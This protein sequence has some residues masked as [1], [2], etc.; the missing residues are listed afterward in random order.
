ME[1][2]A[3]GCCHEGYDPLQLLPVWEVRGEHGEGKQ[4]VHHLCISEPEAMAGTSP[5]KHGDLSDFPRHWETATWGWAVWSLGP[6]L[7]M[8]AKQK[9]RKGFLPSQQCS[10]THTPTPGETGPGPGC[11]RVRVFLGFRSP[12]LRSCSVSASCEFS[13]P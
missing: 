5:P 6:S 8:P 10:S 2:K 12:S 7:G 3:N 4:R 1:G 9:V 11:A 13:L